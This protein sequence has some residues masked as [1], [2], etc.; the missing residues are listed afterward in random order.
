MTSEPILPSVNI[1]EPEIQK[2]SKEALRQIKHAH[3]QLELTR[4]YPKRDEQLARQK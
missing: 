2:Q 4:H 1:E 3:Q